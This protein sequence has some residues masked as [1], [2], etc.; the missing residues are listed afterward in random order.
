MN[1]EN[2]CAV[3][4]DTTN[5]SPNRQSAIRIQSLKKGTV[6]FEVLVKEGL[7]GQVSVHD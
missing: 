6:K 7:Q 4:Q 3:L 5:Q 1:K 2:K